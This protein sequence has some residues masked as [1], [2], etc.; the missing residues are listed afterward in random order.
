MHLHP[1]PT[2]TVK[3][4]LARRS[5]EHEALEEQAAQA[6]VSVARQLESA[7]QEAE[8]LK[9]MYESE[10]MVLVARHREVCRW[11]S[12]THTHTYA[13]THRPSTNSETP[14]KP[15]WP[16]P[17][18]CTNKTQRWWHSVW[19]RY[20]P[21]FNLLH[22]TLLL[23]LDI[24][25][26]S[27]PPPPTPPSSTHRPVI[28]PSPQAEANV[29]AKS[30]ARVDELIATNA[31]LSAEAE[32][33]RRAAEDTRLQQQRDRDVHRVS[34]G[35]SWTG[36]DGGGGGGGAGDDL[37]RQ[38]SGSSL[39]R[40]EAANRDLQGQVRR[41][42]EDAELQGQRLWALQREVIEAK[43]KAGV[44]RPRHGGGGGGIGGGGGGD[45]SEDQTRSYMKGVILKYL[46]SA[47]DDVQCSL[48]PVLATLLHLTPAELKEVYM[49]HPSWTVQ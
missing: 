17:C 4:T 31:E 47:S 16:K 32:T 2:Q 14:T 18:G 13:H 1:H 37:H 35:G 5:R 41:L 42:T 34:S 33:L 43:D 36:A 28:P 22:S 30:Q 9:T 24:T 19:T 10:K 12:E 27:P 25:F 49:Q 44:L 21:G 40:L 39:G 6:S 26:F 8:Q 45:L 11:K 15:R 29:V 7:A 23:L 46:T 48:V 3:D 38:A 20:M